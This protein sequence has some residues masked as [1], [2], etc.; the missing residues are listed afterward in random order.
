M[1]I[2]L[3]TN[4]FFKDWLFRK[5]LSQAF[6]DYVRKTRSQVIL[7]KIIIEEVRANYRKELES[8]VSE[9]ERACRELSQLRAEPFEFTRLDLDVDDEVDSYVYNILIELGIDEPHG[10][11]SY[12]AELLEKVANRAIHKRKPFTGNTEREFKD[13]LIWETVLEVVALAADREPGEFADEGVVFFSSDY[14][15]FSFS[16]DKPDLLH[17]ELQ[18]DLKAFPSVKFLYY[19]D[20]NKF[21]ETHHS[22]IAAITREAILAHINAS[23]FL[24]KFN[25]DFLINIDEVVDQIERINPQLEFTDLYS[26]LETSTFSEIRNQMRM[27]IYLYKDPVRTI[28]FQ[29]LKVRKPIEVTYYNPFVSLQTNKASLKLTFIVNVTI[30]YENDSFGEVSVDNADLVPD[31]ELVIRLPRT[32]PRIIRGRFS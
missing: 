28:I 20:F 5:D 29:R 26:E 27:F 11:I 14:R 2:I 3:D 30:P 4:I 6:I 31:N 12:S 15:A 8:K 19:N 23:D 25:D 13:T 7:P 16:K 18:E 24:A 22:P 9:Y 32:G 21:I 1:Y 10:V 17:S